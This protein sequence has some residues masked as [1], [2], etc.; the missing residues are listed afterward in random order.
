ML[1]YHKPTDVLEVCSSYYVC[2]C[3]ITRRTTII[4]VPLLQFPARVCVDKLINV[5]FL[6]LQLYFQSVRP[7]VDNFRYGRDENYRVAIADGFR[8]L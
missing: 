4:Q 3:I 1:L 7:N 5:L 2:V 8:F 6:V